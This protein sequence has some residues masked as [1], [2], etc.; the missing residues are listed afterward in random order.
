MVI[1]VAITAVSGFVYQICR[2]GRG[3]KVYPAD[4]G[5]IFG[6]YGIVIGMLGVLVHMSALESFGF[7]ISRPLHL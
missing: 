1:V 3:I 7:R 2:F 5:G 4:P 6:G